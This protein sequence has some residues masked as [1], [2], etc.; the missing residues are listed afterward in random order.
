MELYQAIEKR[1][2]IRKFKGAA[3]EAQL[4]RII[5]AGTQAPSG[6]NKQN[7][8][9]VLVDDPAISEAIGQ[10]KYVMNRGKAAGEEVPEAQEKGA[11][12]QKDS[13]KNATLLVVYCN[14]ELADSVGPWLCIENISLAAVAEGLGSRIAR[15]GGDAAAQVNKLLNAPAAMELVAALSIGIP[16]EEAAPRT[17]RPEGS[18]L[19]TNRF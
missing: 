14:K 8:E 3:T 6:M 17:L 2:T 1:R 10:I 11:V 9:F 19:H 7:W 16:D 4:S 15:L 12:R 5:A 13:F 18:W